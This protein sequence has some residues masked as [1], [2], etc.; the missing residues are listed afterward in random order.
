MSNQYGYLSDDQIEELRDAALF[1][2]RGTMGGFAAK[3]GD[4]MLV[5]DPKN[6]DRISGA[7]TDLINR[8]WNQLNEKQGG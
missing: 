4:A 6:L 5:A 8:A 2:S 3:L 1:M 7:F